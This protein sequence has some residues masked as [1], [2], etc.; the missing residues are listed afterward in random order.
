MVNEPSAAGMRRPGSQG[1]VMKKNGNP[2]PSI[3]S[4][5]KAQSKGTVNNT[6]PSDVSKDVSKDVS[7]DVS[8]IE[9]SQ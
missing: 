5:S 8:K 9:G 2:S 3:S 4:T 1:N 7:N 6:V